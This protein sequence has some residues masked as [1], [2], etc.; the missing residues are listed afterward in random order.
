MKD[1]GNCV[2]KKEPRDCDYCDF[3]LNNPDKR[4]CGW[5]YEHSD[6]AYERIA[7]LAETIAALAKS[8]MANHSIRAYCGEII[9]RLND[10][11]GRG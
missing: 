4:R 3:C 6:E 9:L 5:V 7:L 1:C 11:E 10:L 2:M 8:R